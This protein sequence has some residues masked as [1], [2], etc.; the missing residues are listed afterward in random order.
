MLR[1]L[2]A[3][4]A[5]LL[6][7]AILALP[8]ALAAAETPPDAPVPP[9]AN[10]GRAGKYHVDLKTG[11]GYWIEVPNSY[12][13]AKPAGI[14][15]FFHGQNGQGGAEWFNNWEGPFLEAHDLIG[16][17]MQYMDG[18]NMK[19]TAGKTAAARRAIAQ[20]IADYKV[21][22]GRG[23]ICSFSGGGLPHA[24][25]ADQ[26]SK[27]RGASWPFCHVALYSSNY[28]TD[29]AQGCPM[30]WYIGVGTAEWN[31]AGANLGIDA[32][33]RAGEIYGA[34]ARGAC[35]DFHFKIIKDKGHT[36]L[37]EDVAESARA[38]PRSDLAFA[39]FL[40]AP[41]YAEPELKGI[42]AACGALQL[43][44]ALAAIDKLKARPTAAEAV[45]AKADAIGALIAARIER[46]RA[47][48]NGL[49]DEDAVLAAY[50]LPLYVAQCKGT[51][52][53][54]ELKTA[55]QRATKDKGWQP[56]LAGHAEFIKLF[57]QLLAGGGASPDLVPDKV[58]PLEALVKAMKPSAQTA[59]MAAEVLALRK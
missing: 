17:N 54:K 25:F 27:T 5:S 11:Y 55:M 34:L 35:P 29:A 44:P 30:S 52:A 32:C 24:L 36:I 56:T 43:G 41:D 6:L 16:I 39:P 20:T 21:V 37:P 7:A 42:V 45:K 48:A 13:E 23:V 31:L 10:K 1:D 46:I 3:S 49:A 33:H 19:D 50:Y 57:P 22:V 47:V 38:F 58:A 9:S 59:T 40:Y 4:T 53:E 28:R 8:A 26:A 12:S 14:H 18:D 51:P 15:L 2:F